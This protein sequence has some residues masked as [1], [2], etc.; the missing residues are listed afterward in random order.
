MMLVSNISSS[1]GSGSMS[2]MSTP[3]YLS[4]QWDTAVHELPALDLHR[5]VDH[6]QRGGG[7]RGPGDR[8]VL[9]A[10]CPEDDPLAGVQV[11]GRQVEL[12]LEQPEVVGAVGVAQDLAEVALDPGAV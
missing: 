10:V 4:C 9:P 2:T 7:G 3:G 1:F 5:P 12:V 11:S 8:D 6:R